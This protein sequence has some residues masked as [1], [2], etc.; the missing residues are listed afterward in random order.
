[1]ATKDP[2]QFDK[3]VMQRF[4]ADGKMTK[5]ELEAHIE[6]LPDMADECDDIAEEVYERFKEVDA[7]APKQNVEES[8]G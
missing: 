1:M 6:N 8:E 3:R 2:L 4:I 5:E 7:L